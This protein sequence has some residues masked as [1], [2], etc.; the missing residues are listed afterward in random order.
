MD[1]DRVISDNLEPVA[2]PERINKYGKPYMD[3]EKACRMMGATK[4]Y[5]LEWVTNLLTEM[6]ATKTGNGN[7]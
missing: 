6:Y 2:I 1:Y 5:E 3:F 4:G 7:D